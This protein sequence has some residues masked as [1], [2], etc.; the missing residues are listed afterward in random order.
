MSSKKKKSSSGAVAP[1]RRNG[2]SAALAQGKE[3]GNTWGWGRPCP[4]PKEHDVFAFEQAN[5]WLIGG[6]AVVVPLGISY[7]LVGLSWWLLV[8]LPVIGVLTALPVLAG[9]LMPLSWRLSP[10]GAGNPEKYFNFKDKAF[11][12]KWRGRKIPIEE[13]Y[14][15]YFD[16]KL[17]LID[18]ED[19]LLDVLY[20][21]HE[22]SRAIITWSHVKF[23]LLQF[24]PE[25]VKHTRFQDITQVREHYDRGDDFYNG[26]LGPSMI[27]TSGIWHTEDD[28]LEQAQINKMELIAQKIHLKAGEKHL[29]LGCGWG[30]FINYCVKNY[31]T[32]SYGVTLG[33]N[34]TA[35]QKQTATEEGI[36]PQAQ[37][38]CMDYRDVVTHPT[39]KDI[40]FDKITCLEMSEHVGVKNY[41]AFVQQVR[42]M[43]KDDGIFYLQIAGLRRAWQFEDF[44]WGLF[45]GKYVFPGADASCPLGWV[46]TQLEG[47]GF[48]IRSE[49]TI[50]IHYSATIRC[51]LSNWLRP[52]VKAEIS[53]KYGVRMYR[54]WAWFLA[55][56]V[57]SP[58]AG[59]ASCYQ[60][61]AHK[62]T[63]RFNRKQW[64]AERANWQI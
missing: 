54:L 1:A 18:G 48:E 57:I 25:L 42:S 62:N 2:S 56:S 44:N 5:W 28:T 45:M 49:E 41:S 20:Q 34:Q 31:N 51:W 19:S 64:I 11:E 32:E 55:W 46:I 43:L 30:T 14:E 8:L 33:R 52:A 22:F 58:E 60:I 47:G 26:F 24:I 6:L 9:V 4:P 21:R 61:V 36:Y 35:Y 63:R 16:E 12:R 53:K 7:A 40:K 38:L 10:A 59:M 23:F 50:G 27:Y 3:T 29:D 17:D 39:T 15:A 13:L 37:A